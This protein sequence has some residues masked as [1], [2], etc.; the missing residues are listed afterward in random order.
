MYKVLI[1]DDFE[2]DRIRLRKII[3]SWKEQDIVVAGE[4]ETGLQAMD[5]IEENKPDIIISDIEMPYMNGLEM[6]KNIRAKYNNEIKIIFCTLYNEFKY[7]K[8]AIYSNSYGY[9]L[10][11]VQA[12]EL[13]ECIKRVSGDISKETQFKNELNS[14][15]STLDS[16]KP[17]LADSFIKEI[18][19]GR[20]VKGSDI[21]EKAD[22]FGV[23]MASSFLRLIYLEIDDYDIMTAE[24]AVEEKQLFSM[25][26]F[27]RIKSIVEEFGSFP[28]TNLDENHFIAIFS[29]NEMDLLKIFSYDCAQKMEDSMMKIGVSLSVSLSDICTS[30]AEMKGLF[31]QC[32]YLMRYKFTIGKGKIISSEDIPGNTELNIID[33]NTLQKDVKYLLNSGCKEEIADFIDRQIACLS[34]KAGYNSLRNLCF[35]I[36]MCVKFTLDENNANL[37]DVFMDESLVWQKL[38]RFE[39]IVDAANWVKNLLVFANEHLSKKAISKNNAI[40]NE[41]KKYIISNISKNIG[42]DELA[43]EMHYSPNYL[44][45][46]FK[47]ECGQTINDFITDIKIG[48]AKEMLAD[49]RNRVQNISDALG[50]S[51]AAYFCSVFKRIT[52]MTPKE[53]RERAI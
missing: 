1:V 49:V 17:I 52:G 46:V 4:C 34:V 25:K 5:F 7:A 35:L 11:P 18:L 33:T 16:F 43:S 42:L 14:L 19:Y 38:Q 21:Y 39:T 45:Y 3:D 29:K 15:Q 47:Q 53:Y 8:E 32:K 2:A 12:E 30:P 41:V 6:A 50:Y 27:S 28:V 26:I 44:N 20:N 9:I 23:H 10:K 37:S 13:L 36:T 48:K 51:H 31:E 22:Y 40:V 24:L